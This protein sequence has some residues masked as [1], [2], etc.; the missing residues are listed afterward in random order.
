MRNRLF[1][2]VPACLAVLTIAMASTAGRAVPSASSPVAEAGAPVAIDVRAATDDGRPVLDLKREDMALKVNGKVRDIKSLQ[3]VQFGGPAPVTTG[4]S[5]PMPCA[6]NVAADAGREVLFAID[7][8]SILAGNE[9]P[10]K[11]AVKQIVSGLSSNDRVG[12][13]PVTTT[14]PNLAPT[15]D[16]DTFGAAVAA[17]VGH[18]N[19]N[20]SSNDVVC[21]TKVT[22]SALNDRFKASTAGAAT[23]LV[24]FSSGLTP[25]TGGATAMLGRRTAQGADAC[26]ITTMDYT[27]VGNA[28]IASNVN[29]YVMYVTGSS[30]TTSRTSSG[31]DMLTGV[32]SLSGQSGGQ[33]I[34]LTGNNDA[35]LQRIP[36]DTSAYYIATYEP[37]P[38][39]RTGAA[40]HIELRTGRRCAEAA[41]TRAEVA[42]AR[43]RPARPP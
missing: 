43:K 11:D 28:A 15:S 35:Q 30:V 20:E 39:E 27:N 14:A 42:V 26:S 32:Q 16:R 5:M 3:L 7:D 1:R 31:N 36:R 41:C 40:S 12:L 22:L 8:Q 38:S 37:E 18:Q 33:T 25:P 2:H 21:R 13:V 29:F 6:S 23:T 17:V 24:Y 19:A 10:V 9:Q 34:M 4:P